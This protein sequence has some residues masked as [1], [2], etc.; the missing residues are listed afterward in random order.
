M[1]NLFGAHITSLSIHRVGNKINN[2]PIFLS[3]DI[4]KS[5]D[6]LTPLLKEYFLKPRIQPQKYYLKYT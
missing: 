4:Y 3:D 6:E 2:E 5:D 1:I